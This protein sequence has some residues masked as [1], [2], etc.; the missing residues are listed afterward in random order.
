MTFLNRVSCYVPNILD[1]NNVQ[2]TETLLYV[3]ENLYNMNNVSILDAT[4]KYLI[5]IKRFYVQLF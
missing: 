3:K 5:E 2:L 4:I 1:L